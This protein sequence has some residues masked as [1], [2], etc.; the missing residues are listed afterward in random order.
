MSLGAARTRIDQVRRALRDAGL[1]G[2]AVKTLQELHLYRRLGLFEVPL[3]PCPPRAEPAATGLE[4]RS[5]SESPADLAA[6]AALRPDALPDAAR[7]RLRRGDLC[8]VAA[9]G[10]DLV[11]SVWLATG[12]VRVD[13]LECDLD[14]GPH[15]AYAYD[16]YTLPR[17]RGFDVGSWRTERMKDYARAAGHR[18]LLSLHLPENLSQKRRAE[19]RGYPRLGVVGWYGLGPWRH[20]FVRLRDEAP[21]PLAVRVRH[22]GSRPT[23]HGPPS[24]P[25]LPP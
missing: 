5:L 15:Q 17:L 1:R 3:E 13:Y 10:T 19:R 23:R 12:V 18:R 22:P 25:P 4:V 6:Y 8:F 21:G 9:V 16:A 14:L 24:S 2:V 11:S 20:F 7:D